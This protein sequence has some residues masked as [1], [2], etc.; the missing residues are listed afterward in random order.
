[1]TDF[2]KKVKGAID[3]DR[4]SS[5]VMTA[6]LIAFFMVLNA[7]LFTLTQAFGWQLAYTDKYDYSLSGSTDAL[8]A[9]A[10]EKGKK[11]KI[12]FCMAEDEVKVHSTGAEVYTTVKNFAERYADEGFIEIDYINIIT[13][14]NK[15]GE[16]VNLSKYQTPMEDLNNAGAEGNAEVK[17]NPILKTSVIFEC[18]KNYRVVTDSVTSAG[19]ATFF[20][21]DQ[22]LYANSYNGEE[23]VASMISWVLADE[24][25]TAYFTQHH[26]ETAEIAFSNLLVC[27][28]YAIDTLDLRQNKVPDDCDLLVIS[29]PTSDFEAARE[30]VDVIAELDRLEAYIERGG[31]ILVTLDP[32]VKGLPVLEGVLAKHGIRFSNTELEDGRTVR[33]M[34]RES[35]E[36]IMLDGF[37]FVSSFADSDIGAAIGDTVSKYNGGK[38]GKIILRD[39]SALKLSGN[40]K[41]VLVSSDSARLDAG[42]ST[43]SDEGGYTVAA[44]TEY[45]T[46]DGETTKIF[47]VPSVYLAVSDSLITNGYSNKDFIYSIFDVFF[48]AE[49]M[50]Y[51]CNAVVYSS[52]ILENLTMGTARLYTALVMAVPAVIAAVG[53]VV[54]I[55]R[56]NR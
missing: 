46:E 56:K 31:N 1:M 3:S 50:P 21:L 53:A 55:R 54:I 51:G 47:V 34:I 13:K 11:V 10:I 19:F 48:G 22:S 38:D 29:N 36:A 2:K 9:D 43:V 25:K 35:S 24:H 16:L 8:F 40:A 18:G 42:G 49:N 6:L 28:G 30:G 44:A 5:G 33:N 23:V 20:N 12:S 15:D 27:A 39:T 17:K 45:K 7:I 41:P 4:A 52:Q 14:Q 32:Y 37:T 26:G